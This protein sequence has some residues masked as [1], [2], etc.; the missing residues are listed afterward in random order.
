VWEW[1]PESSSCPPGFSDFVY[2]F[3]HCVLEF[4]LIFV[5][6]YDMIFPEFGV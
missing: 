1:R 2:D 6:G 5:L 3:H 4:F